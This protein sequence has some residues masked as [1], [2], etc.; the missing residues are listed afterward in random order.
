MSISSVSSSMAGQMMQQMRGM[1]GKPPSKEEMFKEI[2]S[3]GSGGVSQSEFADL[4]EKISAKSGTSIDAE[5]ALSTYDEDGDGEL[6]S[7]EL[8]SFM[9]DNRPQLPE[10]PDMAA[11]ME[12]GE[13]PGPSFDMTQ[14]I[15]AYGSSDSNQQQTLLS[16]FGTDA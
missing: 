13:F 14:A 3:D 7:D 5:K 11:F 2:D 1:G 8:D 4:T 12:N 16:M 10:R 15:S 6:S 9:T